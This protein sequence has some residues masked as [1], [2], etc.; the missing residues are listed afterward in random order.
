V[1][2]SRSEYRK[3]FFHDESITTNYEE[4]DFKNQS[5]I[6]DGPYHPTPIYHLKLIEKVLQKMNLKSFTFIDFGCGAGRVTFFFRKMFKKIIG[7]DINQNYKK[8]FNEE[9]FFLKDIR[10]IKSLNDL[11]IIKDNNNFVL[12]FYRPIEDNS[13]F[14]IIKVFNKKKI[15]IITIN[16]KKNNSENLSLVYE[17]YFAD[18]SRNIIIYSNF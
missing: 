1:Y 16:V 8:F 17:K 6:F 10:K 9:I 7:I 5:L 2:L 3:H 13:L 18:T 4:I 12:F 14:K 15:Y 11:P